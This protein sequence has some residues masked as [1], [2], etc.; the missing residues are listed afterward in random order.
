MHCAIMIAIMDEI[1]DISELELKDPPTIGWVL[2][3]VAL[4]L[5]WRDNPKLHDIGGVVQSIEKY[6]FQ[7]LPK[8]DSNLLRI[9]QEDGETPLGAV[10]AGNGRIEALAAMELD[11]RYPLPRGCAQ[12]KSTE[13][14]AVPILFGT[15]AKSQDAAKA[16]AIDSN[17]LTMAGG[18]FHGL[19]M[20]RMWGPQYYQMLTG[21][22]ELPV[23]ITPELMEALSQ[24]EVAPDL[25][26]LADELGEPDE[27]DFWPIIKLQVSPDVYELYR[28]L[29]GDMPGDTDDERFMA[30]IEST[31]EDRYA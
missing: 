9:G 10:K 17:N 5:L 14:W 13:Q 6:G 8:Y 16:Y 23:S 11:G 7:E 1:L 18:D 4:T 29:I 22:K 26:D 30:F 2:A 21:L 27:K 20:V 31:A 12:L 3:S 28:G 15:D 25:D 19:D 24:L